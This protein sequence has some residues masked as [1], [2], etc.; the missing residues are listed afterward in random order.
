[1][2][3]T[4]TRRIT[5]AD[6][7]RHAG[8]SRATVSYVVNHVADAGISAETKERVLAAAAQLGYS[9]YGPGRALKSGRSDVVLFVL[10]DMPVGHAINQLVH[11]LQVRF[12]ANGLS[13]VLYRVGP[14]SNP[15]SRIWR[16]IGPCAVIGF[17]SISS[18]DANEMRR[19]G[20]DVVRVS[21][22]A[23]DGPDVLTFAESSVGESQVRFLAGLGHRH[24]GYAYPDEPRVA[25]FAIRRLEGARYACRDLG[26]PELEVRTVGIRRS[27]AGDTVQTWL[28][29]ESRITA[30][31][32]FNDLLAFSVIAGL[33]DNGVRVPEDIAVIGVD[34]DPVGDL[35]S[36][37]ITTIETPYATTAEQVM[38]RLVGD[39]G[40][41]P[42]VE[43]IESLPKVIVRESA[44]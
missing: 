12:G 16:E 35:V 17:D 1:M 23:A 19:A 21:L 37:T 24:I 34:N 42:A 26:L 10:N 5:S 32:A 15:L 44:R 20:I 4:A 22:G 43:V 28:A 27:E 29:P 40:G 36:P 31:C 13:L 25:T 33:R 8:V 3:R 41:A 14:E 7:A 6:V 38:A 2:P 18:H 39:S 11:E 9:Q 30:I